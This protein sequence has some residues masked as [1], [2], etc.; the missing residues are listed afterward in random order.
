MSNYEQVLA[1]VWVYRMKREPKLESITGGACGRVLEGTYAL[2][3]QEVPAR[4]PIVSTSEA[5]L[6]VNGTP[7]H[8]HAI[9]QPF[10]RDACP[11]VTD[12]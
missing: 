2:A 5:A 12:D 8:T 6:T 7:A 3:H 1:C 9:D 11:K 10:L 4:L